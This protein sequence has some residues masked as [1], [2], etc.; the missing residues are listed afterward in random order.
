MMMSQLSQPSDSIS[1]RVIGRNGAV[2]NRSAQYLRYE[3][4]GLAACMRLLT[5][6]RAGTRMSAPSRS[7]LRAVTHRLLSPD[8]KLGGPNENPTVT[9]ALP[10]GRMHGEARDKPCCLSRKPSN[11]QRRR[12]RTLSTRSIDG[13]PDDRGPRS[14]AE[15]FGRRRR[16]HHGHLYGGGLQSHPDTDTGRE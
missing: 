2:P 11:P 16:H 4:R 7:R 9:R 8:N 1:C 12:N 15:P 13:G 14:T 3:K 6:N 5:A 10:F